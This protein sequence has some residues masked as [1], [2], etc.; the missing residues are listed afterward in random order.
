MIEGFIAGLKARRPALFN[1]YA[2]CQPEHGIGDDSST[3]QAKL[4]V[5]SRAY[6]LF[7]YDPDAGPMPH[8]A[9]DLGGNPAI[10][11]VWPTYDLKYSEGGR[12]K[13]MTLPMTFADFAITETR[14]RKH[15]R[16]AP[17]D[18]WNENMVPLADFLE[19]PQS[20]RQG[21]FPYIW[22]IDRENRL[23]RLL[24]AEPMVLACEDRRDF[25]RMLKSI[26]R[27]DQ[28]RPDREAISAEVKQELTRRIAAGVMR[29]VAEMGGED[30]DGVTGEFATTGGG[31]SALES[32]TAGETNGAARNG[33]GT[34][35][36]AE[37]P[38][39]LAPWIDSQ[40]CTSC[41]ECI[42]INPNIFAYNEN[43][44]AYIKNPGGGPFQDL[45]KAA[46]RCT[47]QVIHPG[48][49]K[50]RT[51]KDIDQWIKRAQKHN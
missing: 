40:R 37:A 34:N 35:A 4:A 10:D 1:L 3:H 33:T 25:W 6:P 2:S 9:F 8:D 28:Q 46:E 5:E 21:R 17:P 14:F 22:S 23:M 43:K 38:G 39:S 16:S 27:V 44:K 49:P 19:I 48:L 50:D 47:A 15:F 26:A 18:T 7:R 42:K 30:A 11:Q 41:D 45:V 13:S 51:A 12:E 32:K 36:G 24:V 20:D 31:R 29:W